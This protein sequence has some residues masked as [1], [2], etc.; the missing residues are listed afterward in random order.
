M[1]TGEKKTS[2]PA[3][4]GSNHMFRNVNMDDLNDSSISTHNEAY[5]SVAIPDDIDHGLLDSDIVNNTI[6]IITAAEDSEK[7]PN[8]DQGLVWVQVPCAVD[9]GA[10]A[11]V[12]PGGIF[13][14]MEANPIN[15]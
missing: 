7:V 9:S 12:S 13:A 14:V 11:N 4:D 6:N 1:R 3:A 10:C 8:V 2:N 5:T 15:I